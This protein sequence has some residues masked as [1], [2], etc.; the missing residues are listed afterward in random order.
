MS[1][2]A[3]AYVRVST[4]GQRYSLEGQ[5]ASIS[6]FAFAEGLEIVR[7][8]EDCGRSGLRLKG[9]EALQRLLSDVLS[10]PRDFDIILVQDV[11]RWGRFQD[12]DESAHYEFVCRQAGVRVRYCDEP[13]ER[14]TPHGA[15]IFKAVKRIM[16]AEFS[17]ELSA[18]VRRAQYR[19]AA[20]GYKMG[21]VAGF[22]LRRAIVS[23]QG[24]VE[25]VLQPGQR[26][27]LQGQR[28][29]YVL[30]PPH[31]VAAVRRIYDLYLVQGVKQGAIAQLLNAERVL[32]ENGRSW[33]SWTIGEVLG[34]PKYAG[35]YLFGRRRRTLDGRRHNNP[36]ERQLVVP[37]ALPAIV[38]RAMFDAVAVKRR[39]RMLFL[40]SQEILRRAGPVAAANGCLTLQLIADAPDL[41]SLSTVRLHF[42]PVNRL[43]ARLGCYPTPF[44]GLAATGRFL[45][46][47]IDEKPRSANNEMH[48]ADM[49]AQ[50][51]NTPR[52]TAF[53][54][55]NLVATGT[56]ADVALAVK[57]LD[58]ARGPM[59]LVLDDNTGEVVELDLR[60][61][62]ADVLARI[63]ATKPLSEMTPTAKPGRGRPKL[64]VVPREITLLP[65]HWEWLGRQPGGASA[66]IRRLV[67]DA[68]KGG[69]ETEELREAQQVAYKVMYTLAGH[70]PGYEDAL[71]ALYAEGPTDFERAISGWP[72][73][74][75]DYVR[76]IALR[77]FGASLPT[78]L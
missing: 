10:A 28:V 72:A 68:Q 78:N 37:C 61:S 1:G 48:A 31:E 56:P 66:A 73:P 69:R 3:V 12:S 6:A 46:G 35:E 52:Y 19:S 53:H 13:F 74:I 54:A 4:E 57:R 67:A 49:M 5:L 75:A 58:G 11:S 45:P 26:K 25:A 51:N 59:P 63:G 17:R 24:A 47:R 30:G 33:N 40:S 2:R 8:Y 18:K 60:G 42:G 16:A 62:D 7:R 29:V 44:E 50:T 65:Q 23:P 20:A 64:G 70:L 77:A 32:G 38:D 14:E 41:P 43:N 39:R 21:G 22:G 15:G 9:R 55:D 76:R 27:L 34:N 71:R 36:A